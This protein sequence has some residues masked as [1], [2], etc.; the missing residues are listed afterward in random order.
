MDNRDLHPAPWHCD[1]HSTRGG[2]VYA[3]VDNLQRR[4]MVADSPADQ[5]RIVRSVNMAGSDEAHMLEL[6]RWQDAANAWRDDLEKM[7]ERL[8]AENAQLSQTNDD[9]RARIRKLEGGE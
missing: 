7:R 1:T 4:V 6:E 2:L 9:L 8:G 3:I 5:E